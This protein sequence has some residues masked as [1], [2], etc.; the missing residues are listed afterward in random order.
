MTHPWFSKWF[1]K[2]RRAGLAVFTAFAV[3]AVATACGDDPFQV[4]WLESPDTVLLYSLARPELNLVSGFNFQARFPII[5]E[6]ATSTGDWD[7]AV[8]TRDGQIV[9]LPPGALGVRSRAGIAELPGE[10]FEDVIEAPDDTAA[11][12]STDPVPV[13]MGTIYVIRK[14]VV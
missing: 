11:Y 3:G 14:S 12:T 9:L 1:S 13:R 8:D 2:S 7:I 4:R 5:I 6:R 10:D